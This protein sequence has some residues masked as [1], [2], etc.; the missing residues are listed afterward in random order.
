[1]KKSN[2]KLTLLHTNDLHSHLEE[3]SKIGKYIAETRA[4]IDE[5]S[6]I[7][8]DCG[9]FLDRARLET[10]G[11]M[12]DVNRA[13]LERIGYDAVLP[14][15]N[16]GLS[17][18][19]EELD[20]IFEG[21]SV[22][23]V[24][25]NMKLLKTGRSPRW[26]IPSLVLVKSGVRVGLIGLTVSYREYYR[27][28]GWES[29]DPMETLRAEI[30]RLRTEVDVLILLSH[31]GLRA[32]EQIAATVPGI[33]LILGGHTHHL[34]EV[35]LLIGN[36]AVC[37]AG[38]FGAYIGH[39]ELEFDTDSGRLSVKGGSRSTDGMTSSPELDALIAAHRRQAQHKMSRRVALLKEPLAWSHDRESVLPTLL[40][41]AL[42]EL[43]QA[44]LALVNAGQFLEGL[45]AG[46]VTEETIHTI[47][48]SPINPCLIRLPGRLI[49]RSL[50]ESLLP[51]FQ[52][53]EI[54]G[55]G[56]RGRVLGLLCMD[57][58]EAIAD[59][60]EAPYNR[61]KKATVNGAPLDEH[62]I[63]SVATLDM[64]TFGV[65]YL[66][67]HE[68]QDVRYFLPEFIRDVLSRA[69]N[70]EALVERAKTPRW[71]YEEK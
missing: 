40:A 22:P 29:A 60:S 9:D 27:L 34:L 47:C 19:P 32:D 53:L 46:G 10:E 52:N 62:R 35:P 23:F 6:M 12:A 64:F 51:E 31:L 16:E 50:E 65:G 63:Y 7:V 2:V 30:D 48:P 8:V 18:T 55:F 3:A 14:G 33:D 54:R 68:G 45:P 57:G 56:F 71:R 49:L 24:C 42:R 13:L 39:L 43:A 25:A 15:N 69:L 67:L 28:L 1:M 36:T 58:L 21:F 11:T 38:K 41:A 4:G 20:R 26:M 70:D 5:E 17:Y 61:I 59:L 44:E 66:G 37:A